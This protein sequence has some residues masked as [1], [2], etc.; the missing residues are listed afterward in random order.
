ME[1]RI[2]PIGVS[3]AV[4]SSLAASPGN[5]CRFFSG[6]VTKVVGIPG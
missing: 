2:A 5:I 1:N 4:R 3:G 6:K